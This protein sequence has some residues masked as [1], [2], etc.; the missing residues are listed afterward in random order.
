MPFARKCS[1]RIEVTKNCR[2]GDPLRADLLLCHQYGQP[3]AVVE[4]KD[5]MHSPGAGLQ[6]A[7]EYAERMGVPFAFS[8]NGDSFVFRDAT[9]TDE[10]LIQ[11]LPMHAFPSPQDLWQ[12]Y[13]VWKGWSTEQVRVNGFAYHQGDAART[14]RYY[15]VHAI[16]RA[17]EAIAAGQNRVLLVMATGTGKTCRPPATRAS[18]TRRA[19]SPSS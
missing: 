8:S 19:P 5:N 7:T 11:E 14:P 2:F 12:R 6:Q 18:S 15:Q 10:Q 3:L 16:N 1:V 9:R 17:L 13:C 4:A